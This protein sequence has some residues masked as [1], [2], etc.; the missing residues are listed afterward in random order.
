LAIISISFFWTIGAVLTIQFPL[1]AKNTLMASPAVVSLF[2]AVFSIGIAIGSLAINAL[3]KGEVSARYAPASVVAMGVAVI[4]F[5]LTCRLW[6]LDAPTNLLSIVEFLSW[7]MA[8]SL[9]ASLL[10]IST[11][12][13]MFV[14]PL[15]AFLTTKVPKE[16][17]ARTIAANN[18]F[19]SGFMVLGA[20]IAMSLS[21]IGIA[22]TEQL[23]LSAAMCLVSAILARRLYRAELEAA[24]A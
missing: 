19:N 21:A 6:S 11:A 7:P 9:L 3:L 24:T 1:L 14:V 20:A 18:I 22:I 13:G 5:Y 15:Y 10:A 4:A 12:G 17:T 16:Q 23:L 2:S 8:L